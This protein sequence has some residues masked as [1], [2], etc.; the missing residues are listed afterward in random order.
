MGALRVV[1]YGSSLLLAG[2]EASLTRRAELLVRRIQPDLPHAQ[3]EL[4]AFLPDTIIFDSNDTAQNWKAITQLLKDNAGAVLVGL[5]VNSDD[6]LM[7]HS[8]P[9][10]ASGLENLLGVIKQNLQFVS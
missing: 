7:L 9:R 8:Q 1:L 5:D 2:L 10:A 6:L 4:Q 3:A